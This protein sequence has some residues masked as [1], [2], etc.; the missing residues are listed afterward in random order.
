MKFTLVVLLGIVAMGLAACGTTPSTSC[1]LNTNRYP[2]IAEQTY[3]IPANVTDL[4][5]VA[6]ARD[7]TTDLTAASVLT[8]LVNNQSNR[9]LLIVIGGPVHVASEMMQRGALT[10]NYLPFREDF[11][12]YIMYQMNYIYSRQIAALIGDNTTDNR[13][14]YELA[15]ELNNQNAEILFRVARHLRQQGREVY[16]HGSSYASFLYSRF[17]SRYPTENCV[18][19]RAV[20]AAGRLTASPNVLSYYRSGRSSP[21]ALS[22]DGSEV[23]DMTTD[24]RE[25]YNFW[26]GY[27][28]SNIAASDFTQMFN[29]SNVHH[30]V[31]FVATPQD[32]NSGPISSQE[33][34]FIRNH[35][36]FDYTQVN[37]NVS[38]LNTVNSNCPHAL[39]IDAPNTI[40]LAIDYLLDGSANAVLN[41]TAADCQ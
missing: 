31:L 10:S 33:I 8:P 32:R 9:A 26:T 29:S 4:Y 12:V 41:Y 1:F 3:D 11:T 24:G 18:V 6:S 27:M 13:F 20:S 30:D 37:L 16:V 14:T 28:L 35:P 23:V 19:T 7:T 21:F 34:A 36:R 25:G 39:A 17:L 15:E 2:D 38:N 5:G 22:A 40:A